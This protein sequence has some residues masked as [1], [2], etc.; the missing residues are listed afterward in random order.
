MAV[1]FIG[2]G[3]NLGDRALNIRRAIEIVNESRKI[4][5]TSVS[6][7]YETEPIGVR[8]QPDFLNCVVKVETE[9]T[10]REL[11]KRLKAI[12][13]EMG[14]RPGPRWGPR[15]IDLDILL[16]EGLTLNEDDLVIPHPRA[17]ERLFA[18]MP[19]FEIAP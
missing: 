6:S 12:E 16:Y 9:L 4:N 17:H 14:R 5:V 18:L 8:D 3:S 1:A 15:K 19:L 11:L 7:L 13:I 10:P 2:I